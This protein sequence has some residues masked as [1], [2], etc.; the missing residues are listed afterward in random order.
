LQ[1]VLDKYCV[2]CH[3]GAARAG[4]PIP[5]LRGEQGRYVVFRNGD[6]KPIVTTA[7]KKELLGKYRAIFEPSYLE[8]RRLV[9][10]GGLESDLHLLNPMEFHADTSELVQML[11][12]GHHNVRLDEEAWDRLI[13]WIDLNAPGQGTWSEFTPIKGNQRERRLALRRLYGGVEED[14]EEIVEVASQP[15][16]PIMPDPL[17]AGK[18]EPVACPQWPF[19][20][21]D[22]RRR[23]KSSGPATRTL[24]LGAGVSLEMVK[25][26]A[27]SFVMGDA[28]GDSDERPLSRVTIATPFWMSKCEVSNEQY[29]RFNADHDSRFEHRTSWIFSEEYL[30]WP[31]NKPRQPVVRVSWS[32]AMDFCRW[33]SGRVGA[34]V[35]LPSE[36]EWEYACRAG[37][38]TPL[39]FGDLDTDFSPWANMADSTMRELAYQ[40]WRPKPPDIVPRDAR[41]DDHALVTA[42]VGSYRANAW[43]LHDMHGNAAEW[44]RSTYRAYPYVDDEG[45]KDAG[46]EGRKVVRGGSWYDRPKRCRSSFRLSYPAYQKVY[47]VGFRVVLP[48]IATARP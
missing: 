21:A 28:N 29:A 45:H 25:I 40:G 18:A 22:A 19:D 38:A 37:A 39:S 3:N 14:G 2:G 31:V 1:P 33:L 36:A 13:T 42:G 8:L 47:N 17:P 44:T 26:P 9:R 34:T 46:A 5:D 35:T 27:G 10:V 4:R 20:E 48:A 12:K 15:I 24:D 43:G 11:Q 6:P 32:E 30:G 7:P 41:F 23:Q 16:E